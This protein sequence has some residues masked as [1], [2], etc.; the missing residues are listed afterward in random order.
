MNVN[1][2]LIERAKMQVK[3]I[4]KDGT[5]KTYGMIN[6]VGM[7]HNEML[8]CC[9]LTIDNHG[10]RTIYIDMNKISEF[11]IPQLYP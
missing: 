7:R 11:Q 10:N 3:I 2:I 6:F 5:E 1:F 9:D 4:F 8:L